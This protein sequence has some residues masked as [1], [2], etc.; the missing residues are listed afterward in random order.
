[1]S[2]A[3]AVRGWMS[4]VVDS[5][6]TLV[7]PASCISSAQLDSL[8]RKVQWK[9][10]VLQRVRICPCRCLGVNATLDV[11]KRASL[12]ELD[13]LPQRQ[14]H[15]QSGAGPCIICEAGGSTFGLSFIVVLVLL[16]A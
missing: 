14:L 7:P 3:S 9:T 5:A 12:R 6:A 1:M 2:V 13:F 10:Y 4:E 16:R 11:T 15:G 8:P